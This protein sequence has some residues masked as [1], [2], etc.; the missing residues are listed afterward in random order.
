MNN[1]VDREYLESI[2]AFNDSATLD[3]LNRIVT[4][5]QDHL[6]SISEASRQKDHAKLKKTLHAFR[7][8]ASNCG[9]VK[10]TNLCAEWEYEPESF[11]LDIFKAELERAETAW[12]NLLLSF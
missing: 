2:N 12:K 6:M 10:L 9:F 1:E 5:F 11:N 8:A 3:I 7:G 4:T